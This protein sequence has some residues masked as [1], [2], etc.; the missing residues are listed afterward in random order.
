MP[1]HTSFVSVDHFSFCNRQD[2][3]YLG[4]VF[5]KVFVATTKICPCNLKASQTIGNKYIFL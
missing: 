3:K 4:F 5:K 1:S 2:G